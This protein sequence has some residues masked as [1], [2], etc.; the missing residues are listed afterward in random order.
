MRLDKTLIGIGLLL[1][2][3]VA[4]IHG[5]ALEGF[6]RVDDPLILLYVNQNS[7][8]WGY[9]FSREQWQALGVPFFTPWLIFDFWLDAN[10]FGQEPLGFYLHHLLVIWFIALLTFKLLRT[11][12]GITWSLFAAVFF[13]FG[14]STSIVT[15]QLMS[16]HYAMGLAFTLLAMHTWLASESKN[17]HLL[18]ICSVMFYLAA[19]LNKEIFAPLPLIFLLLSSKKFADRLVRLTPFA[20]ASIIFI[21]WRWYMLDAAVGGY[22][23]RLD[24]NVWLESILNFP[25]ILLGQSVLVYL[26]AALVLTFCTRTKKE[27]GIAFTV[28][29]AISL[30]FLAIHASFNV[31]DLRFFFLPWWALCV[32][33]AWGSHNLQKWLKAIKPNYL[34]PLSALAV[35]AILSPIITSGLD[36][37]TKSKELFDSI[38]SDYDIQGKFL[39]ENDASFAFLPSGQVAQ[40]LQ[41]QAALSLLKHITQNKGTPVNVPFFQSASVFAQGLTLYR[42]EERSRAV[43]KVEDLNGFNSSTVSTT[44]KS[45]LIDRRDGYLRWELVASDTSECYLRFSSL[46]ASSRIPCKGKIYFDPIPLVKGKMQVLTISNGEAWSLSPEFLFPLKGDFLYW[47]YSTRGDTIPL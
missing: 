35:L 12:V 47:E 36:Q 25:K 10:V 6:W 2:A 20:L 18:L 31:S 45:V 22:S 27:I 13:L 21:G 24:L 15:Q 39:W 30:P 42:Y 7:N 29:I 19:M 8:A 43:K 17:S 37:R 28:L 34:Q 40:T 46:N 11:R 4:V 16:R 5:N 1:L 33:L 14:E 23:S 26:L 41:F 32:S 9:F 38:K 44:L 3:V